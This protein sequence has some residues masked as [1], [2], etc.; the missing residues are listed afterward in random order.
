MKPTKKLCEKTTLNIV[1]PDTRDTKWKP[2]ILW[3][4]FYFLGY[5]SEKNLKTFF[6]SLYGRIFFFSFTSQ[7]T[8][9]F[10]FSS[11]KT[12]EN[13]FYFWKHVKKKFLGD[14]FF[15]DTLFFYMC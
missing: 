7:P 14:F 4:N 9:F 10:L 15:K 12:Y 11:V 13:F 3:K 8:F 6:I 2:N 1:L 5:G